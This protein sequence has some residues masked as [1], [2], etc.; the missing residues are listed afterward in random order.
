MELVQVA[1][2]RLH[3]EDV[4]ARVVRWLFVIVGGLLSVTSAAVLLRGY[5]PVEIAPLML[6]L[7]LSAVPVALP[8]MFTVSMAAGSIE[9]ARKG[10][11]VTRLS[12]SEDG[13]SMEVLCADKTGTITLNRPRITGIL[14]S[15]GFTQ[16]DSSA[17]APRPRKRLIRIRSISRFS[18]RRETRD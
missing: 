3:P 2:P 10:V 9:L 12:A 14:P 16:A 1:R 15:P 4:V 13:A 8:V 7:L 5:A 11:L 6:V 17:T 18:P